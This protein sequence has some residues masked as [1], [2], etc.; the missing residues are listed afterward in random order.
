VL[1]NQLVIQVLGTRFDVEAY[2]GQ[3]NVK[4]ALE[5]GKVELSNIQHP[6]F[7]HTMNPGE[8]ADYNMVDNQLKSEKINVALY[9]A[10]RSGK[11][12]FRDEPLAD[13][14]HKL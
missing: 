13:V 3:S 4:V 12:V 11:L 9:S 7:R 1:C 2:P 6:N 14:F 10:W 8:L 5:S